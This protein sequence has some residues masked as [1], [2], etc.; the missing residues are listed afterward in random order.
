M[1]KAN[2]VRKIL[3]VSLS[4]LGDIILTTPVLMRLASEYPDVQID[5]ITGEP[6]KEIFERHPS[7][8]NVMVRRH[9]RS[10]S[11]RVKSVLSVMAEGYDLVIDLKNSLL[12]F[13]AASASSPK[14]SLS[15]GKTLLRKKGLSPHKSLVHLSKLAYLGDKVLTE[16]RFFMP[17]GDSDLNEAGKYLAKDSGTKNVII[18]P[19]AKSHL[20]R[21]PPE[22]YAR[23]VDM[24]TEHFTCN[25]I[26]VGTS[27]DRA[28][29]RALISGTDNRITDLCG[30][31]SLSLLA[32]LLSQADLLITNDSAP[33]HVASAVDCPVVAIFGP[34]DE[35]KYGPLSAAGRTVTSEKACR[36]CEK[37]LCAKGITE[38]CIIDIPPRTVMEAAV[39]LIRS[40]ESG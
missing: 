8:R 28:E 35:K 15:G 9:H 36:P 40:G 37:A 3:L 33:L 39:D 5:V 22:Y 21:W 17:F 2:K 6:G 13:F 27:G 10:L 11:G 25:I 26:A 38:G 7:V 24:L 31:T 12:P 18:A 19:G 32:A 4:N 23:A 16:R 1:P 14:P 29:I 30:R 34:T 20:K